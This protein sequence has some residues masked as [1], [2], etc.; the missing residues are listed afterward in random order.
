MLKFAI[1]SHIKSYEKTIE[2]V[3]P[4]LIASG[5]KSTD[6]NM[7]VGGYDTYEDVSNVYGIT[8]IK[9]PHNSMDFTALI[10]ILEMEK[11][12]DMV[13]LLHDT[14]FVQDFF[15]KKILDKNIGNPSFDTISMTSDGLSMNM[16]VYSYEYIKKC[17]KEIIEM[18]N[19][20]YSEEG[21]QKIKKI[22]V[23]KEDFL[24]NKNISFNTQPRIT[25][26]AND[27]YRTGV[28]RIVEYFPEIGLHKIKANWCIKEKYEI[29]V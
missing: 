26:D 4:S 15:Y 11:V 12:K 25:N 1:S 6:I 17:E 14:I 10:S 23:E 16:G 28:A 13:F 21:I 8:L 27:F 29:G 9:V 24:L 3:I 19:T 2:K 22:N 5:I 7:Y 20:D 18:K